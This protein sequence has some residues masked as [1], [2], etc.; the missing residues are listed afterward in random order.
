M[1]EFLHEVVAKREQSA[2]PSYP[3]QYTPLYRSV[4][5]RAIHNRLVWGSQTVLENI[6]YWVDS[7]EY[8][9]LRV[10]F[11][12]LECEHRWVFE[13][14]RSSNAKYIYRCMLCEEEQRQYIRE[15]RRI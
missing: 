5:V 13:L 3:V 10:I 15:D 1:Q 14:E 11:G 2:P 12:S 4:F 6:M 9:L 8:R 7:P